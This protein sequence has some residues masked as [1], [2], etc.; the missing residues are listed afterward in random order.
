MPVIVTVE[1]LP[2]FLAKIAKSVCL[3]PRPGPSPADSDLVV[4]RRRSKFN[5]RKVEFENNLL[6]QA[7]TGRACAA[8]VILENF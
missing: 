4:S 8:A 7:G 5:T 2:V 3:A 1:I 6:T